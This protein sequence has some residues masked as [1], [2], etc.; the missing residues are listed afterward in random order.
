MLS[1]D[2]GKQE[3]DEEKHAELSNIPLS[4]AQMG[5]YVECMKQ[6][7][8]TLYNIPSLVRFPKDTDTSLL[9]KAVETVIKAHPQMR[10]HFGSSGSDI[11]QTV[12]LDQPIEIVKSQYNEAEFKQYKRE[13]V[14]PFNLR[15]GPLYHMEIVTTEKW[16]YLL[17]DVHHLT[18]S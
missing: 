8:S 16:V 5:V 2:A 14:K 10:A 9:A 18:C 13:F 11:I 12:D 17:A 4:Y 1:E 3:V 15:L 6:P 7:E